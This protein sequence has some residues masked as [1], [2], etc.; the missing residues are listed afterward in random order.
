MKHQ[1][2]YRNDGIG[3]FTDTTFAAK[4][5]HE[6]KYV[7]WGVGLVDLDNDG[8]K[9]IFIAN[10]HVYPEV[11]QHPSETTY[12]QAKQVFRN[13]GN[14]TFQDMSGSAGA[15]IRARKRVAERPMAILMAMAISTSLS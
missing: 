9:D 11:D 1:R 2:S 8:W 10:G 6:R 3:A 4:L 7:S 14:G 5:G 13:R 15:A 12:R